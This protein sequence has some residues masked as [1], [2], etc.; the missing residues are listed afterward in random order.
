MQ[1]YQRAK[2]VSQK[3]SQ[4]TFSSELQMLECFFSANVFI[5]FSAQVQLLPVPRPAEIQWWHHACCDLSSTV[6]RDIRA[7]FKFMSVTLTSFQ[8]STGDCNSTITSTS[9][10]TTHQRT[11]SVVPDGGFSFL[12]VHANSTQIVNNLFH[13]RAVQKW[14][15]RCKD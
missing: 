14:P 6:L 13:S 8:R 12:C 1:H 3:G 15:T 4:I 10:T 11:G 5:P 2:C 9:P 7:A